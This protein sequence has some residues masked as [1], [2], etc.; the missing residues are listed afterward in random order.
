MNVDRIIPLELPILPVVYCLLV[1]CEKGG[2]GKST[3]A[4]VL[5]QWLIDKQLDKQVIGIDCDRS[6]QNF[7]DYYRNAI[8][9]QHAFFTEDSRQS[10]QADNL[11]ETALEYQAHIIADLPAQTYRS[12]LNYFLNGGLRAA[13][14]RRV[15]FV[16]F[17]MCACYYS[18]EQFINSLNAFR[19]ETAHD[20]VLNEGLCESFSFLDDYEEFQTA[21]AQQPFP[22]IS[23]PEI[24]YR[25]REII[26][27]F[28][29]TYAEAIESEHLTITGQQ[30]V[31]D[32][33]MDS[34]EQLDRLELFDREK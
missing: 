15:Q 19:N 12:Q 18:A 11:L 14:Q 26:N 33:L 32:F 34:Y 27:A 28:R 6:N 31:V 10:W 8:P 23:M 20:L 24:S 30:R 21:L 29:L 7:E 13:R 9:M 1:D 4:R 5:A 17:F 3:Y 25:E 2:V 22:I 16:K